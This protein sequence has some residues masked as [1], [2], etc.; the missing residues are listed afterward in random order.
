MTDSPIAA[1]L[2]ARRRALAE[3]ILGIEDH[4]RDAHV[5]AAVHSLIDRDV[6]AAL[7]RRLDLSVAGDSAGESDAPADP[8]AVVLDTWSSASRQHWI[9]TGRFLTV[10]GDDPADLEDTAA[11]DTASETPLYDQERDTRPE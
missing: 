9:D 4:L 3:Q 6:L 8:P 2:N 11:A 7:R 5:L 10:D 1:Q